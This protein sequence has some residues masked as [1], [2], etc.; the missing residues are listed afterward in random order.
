MRLEGKTILITGASSGLGRTMALAL[1]TG[2]NRLI[3]SAR[4][5]G[6]LRELAEEVEAKGSRC[7]VCPADAIDTAACAAVVDQGIA[8]FGPI[9]VAIL[10]AGGGVATDMSEARAE[11]VLHFMRLNYDTVVNFLCPLIAHMKGRESV[12]VYT[13]S[14]AGCFGLPKSGPY[15]AAK[16][17]GRLLLDSC[18][19]ELRGSKI[20]FLTLY[21]GFTYTDALDPKEVPLKALIITKERAAREMLRAIAKGR[22]GHMFP[23][24]IRYPIALGRLLPTRLRN[25]LLSLGA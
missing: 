1:S 21:P 2:N 18:R 9:D 17:A 3:V 5:E 12:I 4:R 23:K 24:R 20:R 22:Q 14:P 16:A 6:L 8:A 15:G 11:D 19:I 25:W 10:N 7:I 13:S